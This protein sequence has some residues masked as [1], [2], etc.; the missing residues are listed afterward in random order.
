MISRL[1]GRHYYRV[2]DTTLAIEAR[3]ESSGGESA[4]T[5]GERARQLLANHFAFIWRVLRRLGVSENDVDDAAQRVFIVASS[6]LDDIAPGSE[7]AFLYGTA[8]R[9]AAA[10]RREVLQHR[11]RLDGEDLFAV[12]DSAPLPD[13][14]LA[15]RQAV[16][17]LDQVLGSM[18][19]DLRSAFVLAELEGLTAREGAALE[20]IPAGTFA[21]RLRRARK[22]YHERVKRL[23][24]E[25]GRGGRP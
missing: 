23:C 3:S 6:R 20:D 19:E 21:S 9:I 12:E 1:E 25:K 5:N 7:R 13:E 18:P 17:L 8:L 4:P 10:C 24:L 16:L 2:S 15:R 14:A 22:E 11:L